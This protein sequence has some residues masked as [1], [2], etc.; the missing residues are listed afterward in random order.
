MAS[1]PDLDLRPSDQLR[2]VWTTMIL[3]TNDYI[4]MCEQLWGY[5][6]FSSRLIRQSIW[7]Q[8]VL[9]LYKDHFWAIPAI[10][11]NSDK[12][13]PK[14]AKFTSDVGKGGW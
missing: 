13:I 9:E 1:Y 8:K 4:D 12:A 3:E 10:W 5:I 11:N 6:H 7:N 2:N 14:E